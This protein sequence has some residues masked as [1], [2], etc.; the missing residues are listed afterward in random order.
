MS[1]DEEAAIADERR[2]HGRLLFAQPC[3]F[4]AAAARLDQLPLATLPEIAFAG[5]SNVG[6]S[7]LIN[8][9]TGRRT[10]ARTSNTPGRTRQ[11]NFFQLGDALILVDLPGYGYAAAGKAAIGNWTRL[12]DAYLCGRAPLRRVML[13]IDSRHGLKELDLRVMTALDEAAVSYQIV[14]TKTDKATASELAGALAGFGRVHA[15]HTALHPAAIETSARTGSGVSDLRAALAESVD[16]QS[17]RP[18]ATVNAPPL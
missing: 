15:V 12:V 9:L 11:V 13:L 5:R 17:T 6:K 8:A 7:S 4:I 1:T 3:Q 18:L 2:E 10:L 16:W 14:L